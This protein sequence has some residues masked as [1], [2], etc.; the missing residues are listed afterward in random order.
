MKHKEIRQCILCGDKN[1]EPITVTNKTKIIKR[2][3]FIA[4]SISPRKTCSSV[5]ARDWANSRYAR[6][7]SSLPVE[8][9]E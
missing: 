5:C 7:T 2:G 4:A 3:E 9:F 1:K 8:V 6:R